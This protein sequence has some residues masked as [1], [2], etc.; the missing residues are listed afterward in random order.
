MKVTKA[1]NS[2]FLQEVKLIQKRAIQQAEL[3]RLE[4]EKQKHLQWEEDKKRIKENNFP[5]RLKEVRQEIK[6]AARNQ[7]NI[8]TVR[9]SSNYEL[10]LVRDVLLQEGFKVEWP[11]SEHMKIEWVK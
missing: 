9:G 3:D 2:S 8:V 4:K 11:N 1:R 6:K 5:V 10:Q 7:K